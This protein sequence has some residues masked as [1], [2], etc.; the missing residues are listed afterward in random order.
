MSVVPVRS[1]RSM[2]SARSG[3][4]ASWPAQVIRL[5]YEGVPVR[6]SN[7]ALEVAGFLAQRHVIL[8]LANLVS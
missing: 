4:R 5:M 7:A 6:R 8:D 3:S 2:P 1:Y